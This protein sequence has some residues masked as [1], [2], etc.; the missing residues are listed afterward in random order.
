[1]GKWTTHD[2]A[3]TLLDLGRLP[4]GIGMVQCY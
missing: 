2:P 1:M 4:W 3:V